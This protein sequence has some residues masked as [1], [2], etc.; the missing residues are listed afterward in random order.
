[1]S[2]ECPGC[3]AKT[4]SHEA[5]FCRRCGAPLKAA[6]G[7]DTAVSPVAPTVP[8]SDEGRATNGLAV[9]ESQRLGDQTSRMKRAEMEELLRR[10]AREHDGAGS[11]ALPATQ[12]EEPPA[13]SAAASSA[14]SSPSAQA[15]SSDATLDS[16]TATADSPAALAA[17]G[18]TPET[19]ADGNSSSNSALPAPQA[20]PASH[21]SASQW[22]RRKRLQVPLLIL[23]CVALV[24]AALAFIALR[25][26]RASNPVGSNA[27]PAAEETPPTTQAQEAAPQIE[28]LI[29]ASPTP[30]STPAPTP[31]ARA[32]GTETTTQPTS[33][34]Q[35]PAVAGA[36][37]APTAPA[38]DA[39]QATTPTPPA[40]SPSEHY[41]RG[42]QLWAS[43]RRAALEEFRAAVPA[44]PDA[45]YYLGSEHFSEG[46]DV[47]SLSD[48]ELRAALNYFTRVTS[49]PHSG[50]ASR[51]VQAL[52][53]EYDRRK[54]QSRP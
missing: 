51:Y 46:R 18:T 15:D 35:P 9:E 3:G 4:A 49:G 41:Q 24:G 54:R 31:S 29:L 37:P 25:R 8:L 7:P 2:R 53:K 23:L 47:K 38:S 28:P 48:G 1:M 30:A 12:A 13:R 43:N 33:S 6:G 39:S 50:Q 27:P 36:S 17:A 45:Y 40:L 5:R 22:L 34:T 32:R 19:A 11:S 52:G 14:A 16:P 26:S 44:V 20:S 42:L 21:S 10:V